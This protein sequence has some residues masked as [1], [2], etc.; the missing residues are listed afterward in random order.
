MDSM[1]ISPFEVPMSTLH[2]ILMMATR[3]APCRVI[4]INGEPYLERYY[5]GEED[6]TGRQVWLHRFL[7]NDA[8]PHLHNHALE[9]DIEVL[10]GWYV[11]EGQRSRVKIKATFHNQ[12]STDRFHRVAEVAPNTWTRL[13]V[14]YK[15]DYWEFLEPDGIVVRKGSEGPLWWTKCK[16]RAL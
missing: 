1:T 7:R 8:E 4:S 16:A 15:R 6:G 5:M 12:I 2:D 3:L 9:A 11:E 14:E 13:L 10:T